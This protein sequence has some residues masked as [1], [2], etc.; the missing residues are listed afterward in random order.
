MFELFSFSASFL[1][2]YFSLSFLLLLLVFN[3]Y[4]PPTKR[5]GGPDRERLCWAFVVSIM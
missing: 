3:W 4:E 1:F 5:R 2:L